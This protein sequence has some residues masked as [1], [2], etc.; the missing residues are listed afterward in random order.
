MLDNYEA[1]PGPM[2]VGIYV[3]YPANRRGS[4]KV[5]AFIELLTEQLSSHPGVMEK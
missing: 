4:V 5:K 3:I 2:D 1:N